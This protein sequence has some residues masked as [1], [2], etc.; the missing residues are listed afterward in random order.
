MNWFQ[1]KR[2]DA[3]DFHLH[4]YG[5]IGR[6]ELML[7]FGISRPKASADLAAFAKLYPDAMVYNT[8]MKCYVAQV[9]YAHRRELKTMTL[10]DGSTTLIFTVT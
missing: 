1:E 2:L 9:D 10:G 7:A 6:K 3:I 8:T 4:Q 5:R